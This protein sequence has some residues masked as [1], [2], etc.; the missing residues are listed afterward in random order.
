MELKKKKMTSLDPALSPRVPFNFVQRKTSTA[1]GAQT[2][3]PAVLFHIKCFELL[4][5][6][7][8]LHN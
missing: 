7:R 8:S 2:S 5:D 1:A 6:A 4:F 3:F